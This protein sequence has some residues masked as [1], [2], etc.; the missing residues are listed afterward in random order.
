M[1]F[2][3]E[4]LS[5]LI[6]DEK[7]Y[8]G[9]CHFDQLVAQSP[10]ST[11]LQLQDLLLEWHKSPFQIDTVLFAPRKIY[12]IDVKNY[13][14]E[15]YIEG[16]RWFYFSGKEMKNPL[17][18]LERC[19]SLF[20]PLLQILGVNLPIE[21]NVVF[22]NPEFTLFQADRNLPIILP[23][24]INSFLRKLGSVSM[25]A[26]DPFL[27]EAARKLALLHHEDSP[28][29]EKRIP[30]YTYDLLKKGIPCVGCGKLSVRLESRVLVCG[31][32]GYKEEVIAG[33]LRN[34][35]EHKLLFPK[36]HITVPG[37]ND[38]CGWDMN[39]RRMQKILS[40]HYT[41][42]GNGKSAYYR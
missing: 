10:A 8:E 33:V 19:K 30:E 42:E 4:H 6:V 32:C 34:V 13:E 27:I 39:R 31:D 9:E 38:W 5:Q 21:A 16:D 35:E 2:T 14:G 29:N 17:L 40:D 28:L 1:P 22:V 37:M 3:E 15:V 18:Q 23:T 36:R 7:G 12:L 41:M 24:Q 25:N 26:Y 20:R 11:Y